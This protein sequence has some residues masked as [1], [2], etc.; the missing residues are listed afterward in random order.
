MYKIKADT[1]QIRYFSYELK[2]VCNEL[3]FVYERIKKTDLIIEDNVGFGCEKQVQD[4]YNEIFK[5]EKV[6]EKLCD[7]IEKTE[8]VAEI[9]TIA[10]ENCLKNVR[11]LPV[12][13]HGNISGNGL[14]KGYLTGSHVDDAAAGHALCNGFFEGNNVMNEDWIIELMLKSNISNGEEII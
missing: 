3:M 12:L 5:T 6:I 7:L 14:N 4:Y 1:D 2:A 10:D 9:Y 11:Q 8:H 13:I